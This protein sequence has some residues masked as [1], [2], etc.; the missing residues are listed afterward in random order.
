MDIIT[1]LLIAIGLS[2]DA[3]AVSISSGII[4]KRPTIYHALRIGVFF[5]GF[6]AVMPIIGW[7]LGLGL[8]GFI[9]SLANWTAFGLL[10]IIGLKMIYE[11]LYSK[12]KDVK[13]EPTRFIILLMLAIATSIDALVVGVGFGLL[14]TSIVKP[15]IIIGIVTFIFSFIGVFIGER[16]GGLFGK[17]VEILGG[18]I[19]IIIGIKVIL[20]F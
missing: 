4:L 14:V 3:F 8:K 17:K 19:L 2:M 7:V 1:I 16:L 15:V 13:T 11:A 20:S 18:L 9:S 12:D 5:G 6:Q 10:L